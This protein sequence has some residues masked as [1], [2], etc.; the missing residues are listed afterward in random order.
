MSKEKGVLFG[1]DD[2]DFA[3]QA[4]LGTGGLL[5]NSK[6]LKITVFHGVTE[7]DFSSFTE[8]SGQ[9]LDMIEKYRE[10]WTLKGQKVLKQ[11]K[12][13]LTESGFDPDKT[14]TI[15]D[16]KCSDPSEAMLKMAAH[17][18]IETLA[19]ARWGKTTVS[20]QVIGSVTYRLSQLA[21]DQALWIIDPRICSHNVLIGLVGAPVSQRVVDYSVRY[22]SHLKESKFTFIHVIPPI[23]PQYWEFEGIT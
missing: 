5:K 14:S 18:G 23:P 8:S 17:E 15:F 6:N 13:S 19:V 20:R 16:K 9:D 2:S 3:Q 12:E 4:L 22:F 10:R 21:N 1:I 7:P 11:A